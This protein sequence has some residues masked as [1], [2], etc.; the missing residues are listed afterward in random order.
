MILIDSSTSFENENVIS[1][2]PWRGKKS[3]AD[4]AE[5]CPLLAMIALKKLKVPKTLKKYREKIE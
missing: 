4:L 1:I 3:D 2:S 5:I